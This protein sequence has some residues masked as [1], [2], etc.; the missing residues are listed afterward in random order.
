MK[1]DIK[2]EIASVGIPKLNSIVPFLLKEADLKRKTG[3]CLCITA[4]TNLFQ[5]KHV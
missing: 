2:F 3:H 1:T 4:A 5:G